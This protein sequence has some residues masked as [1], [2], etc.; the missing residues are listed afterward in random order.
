MRNGDGHAHVGDGD[1]SSSDDDDDGD[2]GHV[3]SDGGH[4]GLVDHGDASYDG[5]DRYCSDDRNWTSSLSLRVWN[6][7]HGEV[8]HQMLQSRQA[9][10]Y[11]KI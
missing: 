4:N 7:N 6:V 2:D 11:E 1:A 10:I 8:S 9:L 5:G 3:R